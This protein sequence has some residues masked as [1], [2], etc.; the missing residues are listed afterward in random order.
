VQHT[1]YVFDG[2][3]L[4]VTRHQLVS[5]G[6]LVQ[7]LNTRAMEALLLLVANA[8]ELVEKRRL[9]Q[10][11]W[12]NAIVEDNNLNQCILAI[13]K[14]L[15][16][17][18]GSNRYIMTVPGRGYR[19]V[20]PVRVVTKE[21]L[22]EEVAAPSAG[23]R[24]PRAGWVAIGAGACGLLM[25]VLILPRIAKEPGDPLMAAVEVTAA[26]GKSSPGIVLRLREP[27]APKGEEAAVGSTALLARCLAARPRMKL[28]VQVQL[29]NDSGAP[30]WTGDY[31]AGAQDLL[32]LQVGGN[33]T[34]LGCRELIASVRSGR[35][36]AT[37]H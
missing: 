14:A 29:V 2:F 33:T 5:S 13:R 31:V 1:V 6:G 10:T 20:S 32:A 30:V 25:V 26:S 37:P 36:E 35:A 22:S 9:M 27:S 18:A 24:F 12:P 17:T 15:G 16:E 7:P 4:D 23:S 28:R 8:G 21:S 3:Q 11:V 34:E 19:F